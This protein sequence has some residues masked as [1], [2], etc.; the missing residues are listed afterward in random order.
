MFHSYLST[1]RTFQRNLWLYFAAIS[2]IG[3]T[4]DGGIFSVVFNLFLLRL[5]YDPAFVGEVNSA[6]LLSFALCSL[7]AGALGGRI[8][9]RRAM[10]IGLIVMMGSSLLLTFSQ[11]I[12]DA[13]RPLW[14]MAAYM[15]FNGSL[16]IYFVNTAPYLMAFTSDEQRSHAFAIQSAMISLAAFAGS[17]VGGVLPGLIANQMGLT[18]E[19]A[20]PYRYPLLVAALMLN[21]GVAALIFIKD[22]AESNEVA[23]PPIVPRRTYPSAFRIPRFTDIKAAVSLNHLDRAFLVL[24]LV[25]SV[26][27]IFQIAGMAVT[28]TFFNVYMDDGLG[29]S[30]AQV[31]LLSGLGRLL[32][33]PIVLALPILAS[34]WS[35]RNLVIG[36]SLSAVACLAPLALVPIWWAAG[37]GY[38]GVMA[39]SSIRYTSFTIF[40]MALIKPERRSF[41]S[42]LNEMTAG[43]SFAGMAFFGGY[44]IV[45][46]GYQM[47]FLIG[48][49]ASLVGTLIFWGYFRAEPRPFRHQ[50]AAKASAD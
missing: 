37:S 8:G 6:G 34:R 10:T 33:V 40:I 26:I 36:S 17:L 39:G 9:N 29:V 48:A 5:G 24:A 2:L 47:L 43:L 49:L 18:L 50:V 31:G 11:Q 15:V 23:P 27:R 13:W 28:M 7:P 20:T 19:S 41:I 4:V 3:F 35:H 1:L 45:A 30:T 38:M 32:A 12:P 25:I 44:I 14:L 21:L 22:D 42:G 46:Y 16:A